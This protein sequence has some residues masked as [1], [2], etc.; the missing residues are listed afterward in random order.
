MT[1]LFKNLFAVGLLFAIASISLS[2]KEDSE[3]PAGEFSTGVLIVNEG[4]FGR[5]D[6]SITHYN[7]DSKMVTQ[8]IYGK[9][10][11]GLALGD[12]VQSLTIEGDFAYAVVNNDNKV[13]VANAHNFQ[14]QH[15]IGSVSLPRY[16][17]TLNGKGYLTEWVNFTDPGR[18]AVINLATHTV[19]NTIATD[20]GSENIIA[21]N[22]KLFVS[23]NFTNTISVVTLPASTATIEVANAPGDLVLDAEGKLW[24][25]CGGNYG[26]ENA[27]LHRINTTTNMVEKILELNM[28]ANRLAINKAK[29]QLYLTSGIQV[30]K[31]SVTDT[32]V[33]EN[34]FLTIEAAVGLYGIGVDPQTDE[35]Y[36]ADAKGFAANGTIYRYTATGT[37]VDEFTSGKGPNGFVF[38]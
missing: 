33:P 34:S 37:L 23:N 21:A 14:M 27:S 19:E 38:R 35:I 3:T 31:I 25:L 22:G 8:D 29:S 28:G 36:L 9:K 26:E 10:N 2:C 6:G 5:S 16:F 13:V 18:V 11:D 1:T 15:V 20:Y 17:T 32:S 7:P 24:V 4:A 30:Y 12:V